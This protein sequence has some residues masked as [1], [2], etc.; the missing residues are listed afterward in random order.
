MHQ[1]IWQD[2]DWPNFYWDEKLIS[3]HLA[4]ARLA[5][6]KLL[7][8]IQ[9]INHKKIEQMDAIVLTEQAIDTSA[10]EGEILN[11]DSVRSSIAN[12]LGAKQ[13][14]ISGPPDRYIEGLLD[15]LQ[16]AIE[17]YK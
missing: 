1:W 5:Q 6:G 11:R 14:G 17:N 9:T 8:I 2:D 10:I 15:M 12:R 13:A 4:S 7:G 3:R 16:D